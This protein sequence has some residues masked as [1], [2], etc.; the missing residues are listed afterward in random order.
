MT[1]QEMVKVLT[2]KKKKIRMEPL[3]NIDFRNASNPKIHKD[4]VQMAIDAEVR[5]LARND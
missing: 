4:A 1:R 5:R 2:K 3:K